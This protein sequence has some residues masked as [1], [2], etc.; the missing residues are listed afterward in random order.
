[1]NFL[2]LCPTYVGRLINIISFFI[3]TNGMDAFRMGSKLASNPMMTQSTTH[4]SYNFK[5]MV[6]PP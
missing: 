1:M 2:K 4:I 3:N 6:T 5:P